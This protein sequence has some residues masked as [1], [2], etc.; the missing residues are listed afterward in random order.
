M[1]RSLN[2]FDRGHDCRFQTVRQL[3]ALRVGL[4]E[5]KKDVFPILGIDAHHFGEDEIHDRWVPKSKAAKAG[6]GDRN[7]VFQPIRGEDDLPFVEEMREIET[8]MF[9]RAVGSFLSGPKV[10]VGLEGRKV[11]GGKDGIDIHCG[12]E[13]CG[14]IWETES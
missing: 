14:C 1:K 3:G 8:G 4:R 11:E 9:Q 10:V 2:F 5:Q 6:E 7:P 12:V 13:G